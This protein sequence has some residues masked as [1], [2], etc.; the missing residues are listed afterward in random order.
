[1][2]KLGGR[3]RERERE[4]EILPPLLLNVAGK[5]ELDFVNRLKDYVECN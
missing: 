3:E 2:G 4:R 5:L 1:M